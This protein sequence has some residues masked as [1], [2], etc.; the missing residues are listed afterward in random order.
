MSA[1]VVQKGET[2]PA[3][4]SRFGLS[5]KTVQRF[6]GL[7]STRLKAGQRINLPVDESVYEASRQKRRQAENEA[8]KQMERSGRRTVY[9]VRSGDSGWKIARHFDINWKDIAAWNKIRDASKLQPG[10]RLVIYL[11]SEPVREVVEAPPNPRG[12]APR[13]IPKP[14]ST[15]HVVAKGETLFRIARQYQCS[16]DRIVRANNLKNSTVYPGQKLLIPGT[17]PTPERPIEGVRVKQ[18]AV[19]GEPRTI[20]PAPAAGPARAM[21]P[22]PATYTVKANDTVWSIAKRFSCTPDQLRNANRLSANTIR[23]GQVLAI[24]NGSAP[25]AAPAPKPRK[26]GTSYKVKDGD[27][28]WK[29]AQMFQVAPEDIRSWNNLKSNNIQPGAILKIQKDQS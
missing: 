29:I 11:D 15:S 18:V 8:L 12:A 14:V 4:A 17:E 22:A 20:T 13:P 27:T 10:D 26:S 21:A 3:I 7:A 23:T 16:A 24:P 2:L 6:N 9:T 28:L 25:A 19:S 5:P 1:H